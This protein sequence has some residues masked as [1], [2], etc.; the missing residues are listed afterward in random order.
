MTRS[1]GPVNPWHQFDARFPWLGVI[2]MTQRDSAGRILFPTRVHDSRTND[3][4]VVES[5][6]ELSQF[7]AAHSAAQGHGGLGDL[8]RGITK[9]FGLGSCEP[10]AKRQAAMN[11]AV[12]RVFRR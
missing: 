8:V 11:R 7:V 6:A 9:F 3:Q 4:A 5:A 12:P 10:C 2:Y 1:I